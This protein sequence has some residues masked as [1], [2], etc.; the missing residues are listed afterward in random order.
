MALSGAEC[1][2]IKQTRHYN[3]YPIYLPQY[4]LEEQQHPI[5]NQL[6]ELVE[7]AYE[8][9]TACEESEVENLFNCMPSGFKMFVSSRIENE[10]QRKRFA[11]YYVCSEVE[12]S[13]FSFKGAINQNLEESAV[14]KLYPELSEKFDRDGLLHIN[15]DFILFNGGIQYKNHILHYHQLLRRGYTSN[16]NFDFIELFAEYRSQT[17]NRNEFRIAI[18]HRR[19][20]PKEFYA[21]VAEMDGWRGLP[22]DLNKLDDPNYIGLTVIERNKNSLFERTCSLDRTEFHWSYRDRI[23]TFE[24]EEI[25]DDRY[26]FDCYYFNR[27]I[28]SER[29]T[30][31]KAFRHLDG[32]VKVYVKDNYQQR[33]NSLMPKEF[34]S[35]RKVKLWRID[36][37]IALNIWSELISYFFKS[38][39]MIIRYFD[40]EKFE[41]IFDLR[42][43]DFEAWKLVQEQD[44][45]D[46]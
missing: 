8:Y 3:I 40:P 39:E 4:M 36:G 14:L 21:Q 6:I 25:S 28:H 17:K 7:E 43:R 11:L 45:D 38:N 27:Y 37:D 2:F 41:Q 18:D 23:K 31:V 9:L 20:M 19:I 12:R 10:R 35:H 32:A 26:T 5:T 42:V 13:Y 24:I 1:R 34:R 44:A 22:F 33:K 29:D 16:P 46:T 30:Q 15:S